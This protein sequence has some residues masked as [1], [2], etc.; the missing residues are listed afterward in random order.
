MSI[1]VRNLAGKEI[2]VDF[3]PSGQHMA[4]FYDAIA[5]AF[6]V[7]V[8]SFNVFYAGDLLYAPDTVITS[9]MSYELQ[10]ACRMHLVMKRVLVHFHRRHKTVE[11]P[12]GTTLRGLYEIASSILRK[13][14]EQFTVDVDEVYLRFPTDEA[15]NIRV[16]SPSVVEVVNASP[17]RRSW[18]STAVY[19]PYLM[20]EEELTAAVSKATT[21]G[22]PAPAPGGRLS[23]RQRRLVQAFL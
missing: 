6:D 8:G 5:E 18:I 9:D 4:V 15:E 2:T 21:R 16:Y 12:G 19:M 11:V 23:R 14:I 7:P 13:P 17:E 1:N 22:T 20:D 3:P 10:N